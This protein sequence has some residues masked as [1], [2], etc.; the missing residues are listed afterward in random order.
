MDLVKAYDT[1]NCQLLI[2]ILRRYGAPQKLCS[3]IERMYQNLSV[4]IKVGKEKREIKQKV[5]VRQGD[6]LSPVLFIFMMSAF[7]EALENK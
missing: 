3:A 2:K 4:I 7:A 5:G 1:T 6:T